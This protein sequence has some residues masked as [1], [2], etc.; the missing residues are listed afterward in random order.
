MDRFLRRSKGVALPSDSILGAIA[1][2]KRA[3][4]NVIAIA[5]ILLFLGMLLNL[6]R[7]YFSNKSAKMQPTAGARNRQNAIRQ[8]AL[9]L[10]WGSSGLALSAAI[11]NTQT[12]RSFQLATGGSVSVGMA[13]LALHWALC[14]ISLIFGAGYTMMRRSRSTQMN[15]SNGFDGSSAPL[16]AQGA[17]M[18]IITI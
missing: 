1:F 18:G 5:V 3:L 12:G 2:Q 16:A 15:N 8:F 4:I 6:L 11:A 17:P 9:A 10:I 14:A 7:I 13:S